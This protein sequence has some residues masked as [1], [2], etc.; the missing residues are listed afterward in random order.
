MLCRWFGSYVIKVEKKGEAQIYQMGKP[1]K[2]K[3]YVENILNSRKEKLV[4]SD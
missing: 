3:K 4:P 2:Q 1:T